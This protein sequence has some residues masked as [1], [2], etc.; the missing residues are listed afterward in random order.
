MPRI[1]ISS[2]ASWFAYDLTVEARCLYQEFGDP[3]ITYE[4]HELWRGSRLSW[5]SGTLVPPPAGA[6]SERTAP[7]AMPSR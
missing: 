7:L 1:A 3:L 6:T 5:G 4:F 2:G